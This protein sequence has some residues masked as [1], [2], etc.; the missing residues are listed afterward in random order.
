MIVLSRFLGIFNDVLFRVLLSCLKWHFE[1]SVFLQK[2]SM[3]LKVMWK[4]VH[5]I[6]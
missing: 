6:F 5:M 4:D 1:S 3:A 2:T